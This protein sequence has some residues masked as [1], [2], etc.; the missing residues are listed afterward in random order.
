[1]TNDVGCGNLCFGV[2]PKPASGSTSKI[3]RAST[4]DELREARALIG[5]LSQT[6]LRL[7]SLGR[8]DSGDDPLLILTLNDKSPKPQS[9]WIRYLQAEIRLDACGDWLGGLSLLKPDKREI[10]IR[11]LQDNTN[12]DLARR[13]MSIFESQHP[14]NFIFVTLRLI[15]PSFSKTFAPKSNSFHSMFTRD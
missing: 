4:P 5:A 9:V 8:L 12:P 6:G 1:M 10:W 11:P 2:V 14:Y 15:S 13:A 3:V 7:V